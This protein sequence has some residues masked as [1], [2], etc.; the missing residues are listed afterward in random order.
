MQN[1]TLAIHAGYDKKAG[2]KTMAVPIY[3]STAY[4]FNNAEHAANLFALK[5]LGNIYS[6]LTNPTTA[7]LEARFAAY[8]EAIAAV[9]TASGSSAIFYSII[10]LAAAGEN[11]LAANNL[12]G[13]TTALFSYTLK[14]LGIEV[15]YFDPTNPSEI[16]KLVD[17]KTR[18]IFFE[19][20]SN[21]TI[22][23]VDFEKIVAIADKYGILTICDNTV[24]TPALFKPVKVGID[25]AV[26]ST[27]KYV[28]GQGL[29]I[30]GMMVDSEK[31]TAKIKGNPRYPHFNEPDPSYHGLVYAETPFPLFALRARIAL[32]RDIG[33]APS[34]FNSWLFIQGLETLALRIKA[35]S[36][37]A[38]EIAKFL[39]SHP[40]VKSVKYPGL[41]THRDNALLKK[42]FTDEMASGLISFE[43][44]SFEKARKIVDS[45]KLFTP[46]VNIGD[47]KSLITHPASTTHSQLSKDELKVA[48]IGESL[49][50][51]S[52][53]LENPIDLIEDLKA[54]IES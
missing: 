21:P 10:N 27:S 37:K 43:A 40:K 29:G 36:E 51:L 33:A 52:I 50:R 16:E 24:A 30:G 35:H 42:Y 2:E 17:E 18:A 45:V 48:G 5:E 26:Y 3:Q 41:K 6:R 23:I 47:S 34:P 44:E 31:A 20:L 9:A 8:D 1:E 14:R 53:G 38:L 12:Y 46:V 54:A 13:G 32:L 22:E 19:S 7:V 28:C 39:E 11:F 15:R 49:V 25:I 4:A